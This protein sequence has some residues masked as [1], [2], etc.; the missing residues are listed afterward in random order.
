MQFKLQYERNRLHK[1]IEGAYIPSISE[2]VKACDPAP[3]QCCLH[4][5][6]YLPM[7]FCVSRTVDIIR[8]V[9]GLLYQTLPSSTSSTG[10]EL[11]CDQEFDVSSV[12]IKTGS[13]VEGKAFF[14]VVSLGDCSADN[15]VGPRYG[16]SKLIF[17]PRG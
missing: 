15:L 1:L 13:R 5:Q 4:V 12:H 9:V 14:E 3:E 2:T 17:I 16:H 7:C 11:L 8:L 6:V 10:T